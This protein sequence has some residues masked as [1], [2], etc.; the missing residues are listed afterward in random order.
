MQ[1]F[2]QEQLMHYLYDDD[3]ASPL[4][5]AAIDTAMKD[6]AV[7]RQEVEALRTTKEYLAFVAQKAPQSPSNESIEAIL[8]YA[9][10]TTPKKQP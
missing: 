1:K 7:L 4:L 9:Q 3:G 8:R 6:D 5:K 10:K 2:T